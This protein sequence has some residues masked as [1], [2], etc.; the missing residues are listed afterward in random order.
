LVEERSGSASE[1][2]FIRDSGKARIA[3]QKVLVDSFDIWCRGRGENG[4][5]R[6]LGER[7]I[8]VLV[9]FVP[10]KTMEPFYN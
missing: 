2:R 8:T 5:G 1:W 7:I 10:R 4:G 3:M 9:V 6:R